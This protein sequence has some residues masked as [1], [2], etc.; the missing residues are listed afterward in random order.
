MRNRA[1]EGKEKDIVCDKVKKCLFCER[2][3][4]TARGV[5]NLAEHKCGFSDCRNCGEYCDMN[6]HECFMQKKQCKGGN[7]TGE[8]TVDENGKELICYACQTRT[9][10]YIFYD[11]E[12]TQESGIHKVNWV[13]CQD[14]EGQISNFKTI[15]TFCEFVFAEH[16][17]DPDDEEEEGIQKHRVYTFIAHNAKAYDLQFVLKYCVEHQIK[18]YCIF[19]G[20]K[21]M[22]MQI[23][24]FKIRFID[25]INF[26]QSALS[27]FPK[28]FGFKE[29]KKGFFPHYCNKTC[30]QNYIGPIPNK[31][32][33]GPD[34]MSKQKRKEFHE[35]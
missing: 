9:E 34:Q 32:H 23:P 2:K 20:T 8:H 19:N 11:F 25:S 1:K 6:I 29:L 27:M 33:F 26:V 10:N 18:P 4:T 7:C 35:W 22:F 24:K 5:V 15:E 31:K 16:K 30:N 21:I 28:T 13:D 3:L 17:D 12:A 14:F